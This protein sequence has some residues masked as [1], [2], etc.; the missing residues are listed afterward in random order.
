MV[1]TVQTIRFLISGIVLH[2]SV[3]GHLFL[4][5]RFARS[6]VTHARR[7]RTQRHPSIV[8][9]LLGL[10]LHFSYGRRDARGLCIVVQQIHLRFNSNEMVKS[11]DFNSL[12]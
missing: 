6:A 8:V 11:R 1:E 5:G 4:N 3:P 9:E 2:E 7:R 12:F 10:L